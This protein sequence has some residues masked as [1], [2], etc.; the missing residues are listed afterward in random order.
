LNTAQHLSRAIFLDRDGTI[1]KEI[2][3]ENSN[4]EFGYVTKPEQVELIENSA[5]AI[6]IAR[7]LG[8]KIIIVS[9]QSAIARGM[10]TENELDEINRVMYDLLKKEDDSAIIDDFYYSPY[11]VDGKIEKYKMHHAS[12]KPDTGMLIDAQKKYNL[13]L[14]LSYMIG[15]SNTDMAAGSKAGC[16]NILVLTGYG[17]IAKQKCLDER[18]KIDFIADNLLEAVK[19][20]DKNER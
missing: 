13:N 19:F 7:G 10:I 16:K 5:K 20:I 2:K 4:I 1:L 15:D 6:S 9:N 12:R 11:H 3:V 8:Y 14:S 17:K 18:I